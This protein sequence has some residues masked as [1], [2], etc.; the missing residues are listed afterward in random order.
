MVVI[1]Y[2]FCFSAQLTIYGQ[3]FAFIHPVPGTQALKLDDPRIAFTWAQV[4][5]LIYFQAAELISKTEKDPKAG[6]D[7]EGFSEPG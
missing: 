6:Y 4:L 2:Y 3:H 5:L 1:F 7:K